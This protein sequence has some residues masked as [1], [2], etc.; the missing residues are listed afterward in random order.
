MND[1]GTAQGWA[2]FGASLVAM[3]GAVGI[4]LAGLMQ[5]HEAATPAFVGSAFIHI[6]AVLGAF[7]GGKGMPQRRAADTRQRRTDLPPTLPAPE[8]P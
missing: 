1:N 6:A 2:L 3:M 4:D 8:R 7:Y 5:W